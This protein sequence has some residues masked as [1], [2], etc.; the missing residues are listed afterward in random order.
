M[1]YRVSTKLAVV[2][3]LT[4]VILLALFAVNITVSSRESYRQEAVQSISQSYAGAQTIV[5]PVLALS[6]MQDQATSKI[7]SKGLTTVE[8]T[9]YL[10]EDD[11]FQNLR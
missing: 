1:N 6:Y 2:A 5:G 3:L 4:F 8:H 9:S 11:I 10:A 7:D